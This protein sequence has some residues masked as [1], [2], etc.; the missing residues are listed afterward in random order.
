MRG[1]ACTENI[2]THH[3]HIEP[4][5]VKFA[6]LPFELGAHSMHVLDV[7]F[8]EEIYHA[9][10]DVHTNEVI[11]EWSQLLRDKALMQ[12]KSKSGQAEVDLDATMSVP[13]PQAYSMTVVIFSSKA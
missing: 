6:R 4:L 7:S 8:I 3:D 1:T 2:C 13:V 12:Q 5:V 11:T 9:L 10:A